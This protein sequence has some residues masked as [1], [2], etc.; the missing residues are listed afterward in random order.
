MRSRRRTAPVAGPR[1][2][3]ARLVS[4]TVGGRAAERTR[5]RRERVPG[6]D[7]GGAGRTSPTTCATASRA[8]ERE[9][10]DLVSTR[11]APPRSSGCAAGAATIAGWRSWARSWWTL[12]A[13]WP[14]PRSCGWSSPPRWERGLHL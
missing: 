4:G 11:T 1:P 6:G 5:P 7:R 14:S 10:A 2:S 12:G 8:A 9:V 3:G 13:G